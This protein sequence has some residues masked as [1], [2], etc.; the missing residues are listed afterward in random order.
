MN[1]LELKNTTFGKLFL[2]VGAM[3][4][5]TT[6]L[7][8]ILKDHPA[9]HF[10]PEKEIHYWHYISD[11]ESSVL[12]MASREARYYK[13]LFIP[14]QRRTAANILKR[15]DWIRHY[16]SPIVDDEWYASLFSEAKDNQYWCDFSNLTSFVSDQIWHHLKEKS[17]GLKVL[18]TM[19][20]PIERLWSHVCFELT[21]VEKRTFAD[22]SSADL[23][24]MAKRKDIL[25]QGEYGKVLTKLKQ[26][27]S[28]DCL[29]VQFYENTF[30][31]LPKAIREIELF[32]NVDHSHLSDEKKT[33]VSNATDS[34]KMPDWF[35]E[36]F[37]A[38]HERIVKEILQFGLEVPESWL[39]FS[40]GR[41]K[42]M[43]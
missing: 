23:L 7:F 22:L 8:Q 11:K 13:Y 36:E 12:D 16:Y 34:G 21:K 41:S 30:K 29:H 37:A 20:S 14:K 32:L 18:Y 35:Y 31:D 24:K 17:E 19:R 4:C 25:A 9:L 38:F 6:T 3:K 10:T 43:A 26:H 1:D 28:D 5:G 15:S 39:W 27:V 42:T 2:S 40:G 33:L